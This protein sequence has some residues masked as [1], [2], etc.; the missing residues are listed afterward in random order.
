RVED[1][2]SQNVERRRYEVN[3]ETG[4]DTIKRIKLIFHEDLTDASRPST[5]GSLHGRLDPVEVD[6]MSREQSQKRE[7]MGPDVLRVTPLAAIEPG[8]LL[9]NARDLVLD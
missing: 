9:P 4:L 7:I 8:C 6:R 2:P 5:P 1:T 3:V